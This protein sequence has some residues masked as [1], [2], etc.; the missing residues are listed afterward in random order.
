M[1]ARVTTLNETGVDSPESEDAQTRFSTPVSELDDHRHQTSTRPRGDTLSASPDPHSTNTMTEKGTYLCSASRNILKPDAYL[2]DRREL[3]AKIKCPE[4]VIVD[5][6]ASVTG[7]HLIER[8][9][10][11]V[12]VM[13]RRGTIRRSRNHNRSRESSVSSRKSSVANSVDAFA[14][15]RRRE[16]A[17]TLDS[18]AGSE[19]NLDL[20]RTVSSGTHHRRP[21]FSSSD[22][23]DPKSQDDRTSIRAA[24]E[25]VCFPTE[26][27][28]STLSK[29][30]FEELDEFLVNQTKSKS[31]NNSSSHHKFSFSS[32][33]GKLPGVSAELR[34]EHT[35]KIITHDAS[36]LRSTSDC[37]GVSN[38]T[39][40]NEKLD[41]H[42]DAILGVSGDGKAYTGGVQPTRYSFFS[43]ELE[44][45]IL[46]TNFEDLLSPG[47]TF[48]DL[49][50]L[51]ED[52][53]LW[54]LDIQKPT[55]NEMEAFQKA[56]GI[57]RL[58]T[59]DI[60]TQEAREKVELFKQ[61]YFVC[62]R[63]FFQVDEQHEDYMEPV[64][65]YMVVFREGVITIT[66]EQSPHATNVRKRIGRLRDYMSLT[67]DWVCYAM[68]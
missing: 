12:V 34:A 14:G 55:E 38:D 27:Q 32:H 45:T 36:S 56:F 16:R 19:L 65:V 59:E 58:T 52:G 17:N 18:R 42:T 13:P 15:P 51:P 24:E 10:S 1:A 63:S 40:L 37:A 33:G 46:A 21:T 29:I 67:A 28:P 62:F 6:D 47:E 7:E 8:R 61:Y 41:A 43:T 30:D 23:R 2:E 44:K 53:G 35:P 50:D 31:G 57:H 64:N 68:M 25:D 66:Y 20:Q 22:V 48:R 3:S 39:I 26:I 60:M 54:W 9:G 4:H 11:N 49:F 5:D